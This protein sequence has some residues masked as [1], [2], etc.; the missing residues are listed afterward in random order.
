MLSTTRHVSAVTESQLHVS[1]INQLRTRRLPSEDGRKHFNQ[2]AISSFISVNIDVV[3][4]APTH[5]GQLG[6]HTTY[7]HECKAVGPVPFLGLIHSPRVREATIMFVRSPDIPKTYHGH[8]TMVVRTT[9]QCGFGT[10][11]QSWSK[12]GSISQLRQ[13][14]KTQSLYNHH[15]GDADITPS[16]VML[17][18][19]PAR[20]HIW[21]E[22]LVT[23][24]Q[25]SSFSASAGNVVS[26]GF[27]PVRIPLSRSLLTPTEGGGG[28]LHQCRR[29]STSYRRRGARRSRGDTHLRNLCQRAH[30]EALAH[31]KADLKSCS[32]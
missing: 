3:S 14:G 9:D 17:L 27:R 13:C 25:H 31:D 16:S 5:L 15:A 32:T 8:T 6:S 23:R 11:V 2:P 4:S 22:C 18:I 26:R 21:G 1:R 19:G 30:A 28:P 20:L 24:H 12:C 7:A 29:G 10:F